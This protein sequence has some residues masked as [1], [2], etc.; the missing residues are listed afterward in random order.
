MSSLSLRRAALRALACC[1]V[2]AAANSARAGD[3]SAA[4]QALPAA[5]AA[6]QSHPPD[7]DVP[8]EWSVLDGCPSRDAVLDGLTGL[9]DADTTSW[10][11]FEMVQG[12]ITRGENAFELRLEFISGRRVEQRTFATRDC[13]DLAHAA[14]VALALVLDPAWD[15]DTEVTPSTDSAK[16]NPV[17]SEA[18][19]GTSV[20]GGH[21]PENAKL[22]FQLGPEVLIDT[23]TLGRS[24]FGLGLLARARR[25]LWET[26]WSAEVFGAWLP[27]QR[28]DVRPTESVV[29]GLTS[30]GIRACNW[31]TLVLG[32][33]AEAE[34]GRLSAS[35]VGESAGHE[36]FDAWVAPGASVVLESRLV[37]GLLL[38]SR[39]GLLA[40]LTRPR[41]FVNQTEGVHEVPAVAVRAALGLILT[42]K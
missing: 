34:A 7:T 42:G 5:S 9:L 31:P 29:L 4:Q 17:S 21:A 22:E 36:V 2:G 32:L 10:D 12:R 14:A 38:S 33:C 25:S 16:P 30:A 23:T 1:V 24:A 11:R 8:F 41:Y 6:V 40:P 35:G 3:P 15:W 20:V 28:I 27:G 26:R 39:V 13:A 19:T 18:D 37:P